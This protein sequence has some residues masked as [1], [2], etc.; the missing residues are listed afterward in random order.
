MTYS[1]CG[2]L[3]EHHLNHHLSKY[4][5]SLS[6]CL[7]YFRCVSEIKVWLFHAPLFIGCWWR[8]DIS[9]LRALCIYTIQYN[10]IRDCRTFSLILSKLSWT[11]LHANNYSNNKALKWHLNISFINRPLNRKYRWTLHPTSFCLC[12]TPKAVKINLTFD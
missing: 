7:N 10:T 9:T 4:H 11:I 1:V 6:S 5:L 12:S 8:N 3:Q 2:G